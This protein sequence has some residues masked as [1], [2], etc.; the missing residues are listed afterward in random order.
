VQ[1]ETVTTEAS[2]GNPH[3]KPMKADQVEGGLEWYHDD[4]SLV[5]GNIFYKK[6]NTFI[7][8]ATEPQMVGNVQYEVTG[9]F[10]FSKGTDI[11]GFEAQVEQQ[12]MWGFGF[13]LNYTYTEASVPMI[14]GQPKMKLPGN[15]KHQG[16]ASLYYEAGPLEARLSVNYR[17]D[18]AG[19]L[20]SGG[21]LVTDS[22]TRLDASA[23]YKVTD[24][25]SI[26]FTA[27]NMTDAVANTHLNYGLP[28]GD[29][30][31]GARY[32]MGA[33]FKF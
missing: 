7:Y 2:V 32:S 28:Y 21:Q 27:V 10:N 24:Y 29:Y 30:E 20:T 3:L 8:T 19:G 18:A 31:T 23:S 25:A 15:S 6:L 5:A 14:P 11:L 16:N 1:N 13:S 12:L 33:R 17:S 26:F 9:P 22:A 4:A